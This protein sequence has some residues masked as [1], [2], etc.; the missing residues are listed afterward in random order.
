MLTIF[1]F[2]V[3]SNVWYRDTLTLCCFLFAYSLP[4]NHGFTY[5]MM[6]DLLSLFLFRVLITWSMTIVIIWELNQKKGK[7]LGFVISY[8]D[9]NTLVLVRSHI[10]PGTHQCVMP[11]TRLE[12]QY[13]TH[14]VNGSFYQFQ[15]LYFLA[16]LSPCLRPEIFGYIL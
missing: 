14:F 8:L 4:S 12:G 6:S 9:I 15:Y 11:W 16:Y 3:K 1:R 13:S 2:L 5:T 7:C 10:F